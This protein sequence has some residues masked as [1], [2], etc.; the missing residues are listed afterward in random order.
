[1]NYIE[2]LVDRYLAEFE[3]VIIKNMASK[4]RNASKRFV[5]SL[6][7]NVVTDGDRVI[8]QSRALEY[9]KWLDQ[10]RGPG[11]FPPRQAIEEW[12]SQK[13]IK[14]FEDKKGKPMSAKSMAFIISRRMANEGTTLF[15]KKQND[16]VI[17]SALQSKPIK[18]LANDLLKGEVRTFREMVKESIK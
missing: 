3:E 7:R 17:A 15:R 10:G 13:N 16:M 5:K 9:F 2:T 4:D 8:G 12:I 11:K 6:K 1:M 14:P 18:S